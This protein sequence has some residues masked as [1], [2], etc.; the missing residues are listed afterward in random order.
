MPVADRTPRVEHADPAAWG[1]K[2]GTRL[3]GTA[4]SAEGDIVIAGARSWSMSA[5]PLL[6]VFLSFHIRAGPASDSCGGAMQAQQRSRLRICTCIREYS[7]GLDDV[8]PDAQNELY[9]R[10]IGTAP[11]PRSMSVPA[12][13]KRR[14]DASSRP[15]TASSKG[16]LF[17]VLGASADA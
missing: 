14:T 8:Q 2:L 13:V 5:A 4:L 7:C 11:S 1:S 3:A 10:R 17:D 15:T 6:L 12:T 16:D 9:N